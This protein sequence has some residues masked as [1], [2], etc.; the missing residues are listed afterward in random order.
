MTRGIFILGNK[1]SLLQAVGTEALKRVQQYASAVIGEP[2]DDGEKTEEPGE[3]KILLSW[4]PSSPL[5]ARTLT[6]AAENRLGRLDDVILVCSPPVLYRPPDALTPAEIEKR[7]NEEIKSWFFLARELVSLFKNRGQG[8]LALAVPENSSVSMDTARSKDIPLDLLGTAAAAS[9]R[10][11]AQGLL[12]SSIG[13]SYNT[14]G[15]IV[16]E[17]GAEGD[18]ASWIL[19]TIDDN[20]RKNS[21]RWHKYPK[22]GFFR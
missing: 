1:S 8:T 19:K 5:S 21:G 6:L 16:P 14:L 10:V 3:G 4:N 22:L 17:N 13:A 15:F 9:F 7:I 18:I 11:L 12:S 2:H 20:N